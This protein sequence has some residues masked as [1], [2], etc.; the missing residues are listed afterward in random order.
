M[1]EFFPIIC[2]I[3]MLGLGAFMAIDPKT[4]TKKEMRDDEKAVAKIRRNG[5]VIIGCGV[6][7]I[8]LGII[9]VSL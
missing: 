5:F 9:R 2:G 7:T 4:S 8:I 1:Y 6:V 3:M